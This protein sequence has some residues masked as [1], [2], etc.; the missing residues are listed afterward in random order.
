MTDDSCVFGNVTLSLSR[1]CAA[2]RFFVFFTLLYRLGGSVSLLFFFSSLFSIGGFEFFNLHVL[3]TFFSEYGSR[4]WIV[5]RF[6]LFRFQLWV[7]GT[8]KWR[9]EDCNCLK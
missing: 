2:P 6:V 1:M 9:G 8:R 7:Q 5:F 4:V 3:Y